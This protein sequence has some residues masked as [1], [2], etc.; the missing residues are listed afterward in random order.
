VRLTLYEYLCKLKLSPQGLLYCQ[1]SKWVLGH[2][3]GL[4]LR[5]YSSSALVPPDRGTEKGETH[6]H[7]RQLDCMIYDSLLTQVMP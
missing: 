7:H 5:A 2:W 6:T 4:Y 3:E 1:W